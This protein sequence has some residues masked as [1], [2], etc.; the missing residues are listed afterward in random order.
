MKIAYFTERPYRHVNEDVVL[1]NKAFF[2]VPNSH[3]DRK[4]G[5]DDYNH[6]LDEACY[7]EEHG[8]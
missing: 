4:K 6:Y 7:A 2:A 5:S 3:F 8:L 1:K